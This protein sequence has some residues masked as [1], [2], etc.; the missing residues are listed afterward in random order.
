[1]DI[2]QETKERHQWREKGKG[3]LLVPSKVSILN[4]SI[5]FFCSVHLHLLI[6]AT[7]DERERGKR[8]AIDTWNHQIRSVLRRFALFNLSLS[9]WSD[10]LPSNKVNQYIFWYGS[11]CE[12]YDCRVGNGTSWQRL[13]WHCIILIHIWLMT[14]MKIPYWDRWTRRWIGMSTFSNNSFERWLFCISSTFNTP[15]LQGVCWIRT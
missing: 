13:E 5:G 3:I 14:E 12:V 11:P 8:I 1:M 7:E 15:W 2:L 9:R 6:R 4:D 10:S